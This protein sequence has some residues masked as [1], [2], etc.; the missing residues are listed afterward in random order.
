M[1][2]PQLEAEGM[3]IIGAYFHCANSQMEDSP[4]ETINRWCKLEQPN[5]AL[6]QASCQSWHKFIMGIREVS[7][8]SCAKHGSEQESMWACGFKPLM[9][10][11][12]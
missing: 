1:V 12:G 10:L 4:T 3:L 9:A 7:F 6:S 5:V 11:G 2:H 8:I